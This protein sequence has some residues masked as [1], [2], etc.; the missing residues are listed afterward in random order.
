MTHFL[1]HTKALVLLT[2]AFL[3]IGIS[4]S[5]QEKINGIN[6][7][8]PP[9]ITSVKDLA[10]VKKVSADWISLIPYA[11][12]RPNHTF[13]KF[14]GGHQW[15][16]ETSKGT[17]A[18]VRQ[19]KTLGFNVMLKPHIWVESQ[20]WAGDFVLK[21]ENDWFEWEK[22]YS[23]YILTYAKIAQKYQVPLLCIGTELRQVVKTR[24]LFWKQLIKDIK[25]VYSGKL[26]Y[27]ANWDNYE[28]VSFWEQLDYIG[29]DGYFPLSENKIQTLEDLDKK[30]QPWQKKLEELSSCYT[31]KILFTEYGYQSCTFNTKTPWDSPSK[32]VSEKCQD[33]AYKSFY[34]NIWKE[35]WCQGG[36]LWKWH[37]VTPN[38]SRK[39]AAF[40]PQGKLVI[41]TIKKAYQK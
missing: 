20:G 15:W 3:F 8:A 1:Q 11:F 23:N 30:W 25:A 14:D 35:D 27:A 32:E 34:K 39:K 16:G 31:K 26:T 28:N 29:I 5:C 18:L 7:V 36:F 33:I 38:T 40:T 41:Q 13:V 6:L 21:E 24:P 4:S 9:N 2:G 17:I 19:A 12:M 10:T 37:L 22:N